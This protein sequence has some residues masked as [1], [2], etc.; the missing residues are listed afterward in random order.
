MIVSCFLQLG[1]QCFAIAVVVRTVIAAPPRSFRIFDGPYGYDSSG[2]WQIVPP[3]TLALFLVA[4]I[5]NWNTQ[6]R[7]LLLYALTLFLIAGVVAGLFLEP[8]FDELRAVGYSDAVDPALQRRAATWYAYDCAVWL[9][10][11]GSGISL[12]VALARA[13]TDHRG[14]RSSE[15]SSH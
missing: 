3:I 13:A 9:L 7:R 11:L 10:G 2:F 15:S 14:M 6:R 12:L 4:L 1:A 8:M 5:A